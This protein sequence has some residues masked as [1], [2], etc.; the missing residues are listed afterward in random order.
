[1]KEIL[2]LIPILPLAGF[3]LNA[4]FG[5]KLKKD[6]VSLIGVGSIGVSLLFSFYI[7]FSYLLNFYPQTLFFN[8]YFLTDFE[9]FKIDFGFQIDPLSLIMLFFVNFVGFWI[10]LYS[11]G[12]MGKEEGYSRYFAYLNLF[13]FFMLILSLANNFILMFVGWEGVGLCSYLLIGFYFKEEWPSNAGRK[14]FIVNR[15]GD[16]GFLLGLFLLFSE[17]G[18]FSFKELFEGGEISLKYATPIALLLFMGATGKSAQIPLYVW[19]PDAMAGPTPVSALIHAAT[20]VTAGV[21]MVSRANPIFNSSELASS[22]IIIICGLTAFFSATMALTQRDIKKILAYSTISQLGYMFMATGVHKYHLGIFHVF[23]HSF[24]KACL[25]LGAGALIHS[26]HTNDIFEMGGMKDK[27]KKTHWTFLFATLA[28]A[29]IPP[30]A[31]FFSK[32]AILSSLFMMGKEKNWIYI[33]YILALITAFLTSFYM[34]RLYYIV[35]WGKQKYK[36]EPHHEEKVMAV[37]LIV[38]AI[39]S[40][41][42]GFIGI[43]YEKINLI[44]KYFYPFYKELTESHL[45]HK[46]EFLLIFFSVLAAFLGMR[47]A[48]VLYKKDE[49]YSLAN[50]I[51]EKFSGIYKLLFNKYYVDEFYHLG[52]VRPFILIC[53]ICYK[54]IDEILIDGFLLAIS[55]ILQTIGEI[56]RFLQT[57]NAKTYAIYIITGVVVLIWIIL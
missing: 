3:I 31:G 47:L 20:M 18:T 17:K 42:S 29:G 26:L 16:F 38:L 33:F 40:L 28:I 21:Y 22:L 35:F 44:N 14:A 56:L 45:P 4:F 52:F 6:Y 25:F 43:P 1:M 32:D 50:K 54:I 12:Y 23:T 2:L 57:G 49:E 37:P 46:T 27:M 53:K 7:I 8:Y 13:M 48:Y 10:H 51:K 19:L 11:I 15:I 24:F 9:G 34:F 55:F 5:R 30:F 41:V 39:G 36:K